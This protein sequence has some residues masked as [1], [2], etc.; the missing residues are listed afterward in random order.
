MDLTARPKDAIR[1]ASLY[2]AWQSALKRRSALDELG[3]EATAQKLL[4]TIPGIE[5][6]LFRS[7]F[8]KR[9]FKLKEAECPGKPSFE[10]ICEQLDAGEF[11]AM[12]LRHFGSRSEEDEAETGS[13]HLGKAGQVKIKKSRVETSNPMNM[14]EF[15]SKINL[16]IN[17]LIFARF[18]Y[19]HKASL[20]DITPC[21][22]IEYLNYICSKNVAQLEATT[23]DDISLHRPSLKLILSYECQM[24]K[25]VVDMVN[26]GD[27]WVTARKAV[28]KNADVRERYFSTPLAVTSATQSFKRHRG[29]V[30]RSGKSD[31][32]PTA[33]LPRARARASRRAN[34]RRRARVLHFKVAPR[35]VVSFALHG[36]TRRRVA[37]AA[38]DEFMLA[39]FA[40]RPTMPF[41]TTSR[42][43]R[44]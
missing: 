28:V 13:L 22:A 36:T 38:V 2:L 40:S 39:G 4:K 11:R 23:V 1:L 20:A 10:D 25:E 44:D 33:S 41:L 17:H 9:F 27:N 24:R 32:I 34:R 5:M 19:P 26:R 35:M 29:Q 18:R 15:R 21:T 14:E 37:L 8:E 42:K 30:Q 7:E 6:Q 43:A 16:M 12:A 31:N 3:A